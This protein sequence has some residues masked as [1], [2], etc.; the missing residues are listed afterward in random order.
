MTSTREPR[1][2]VP[3]AS[4]LRALSVCA[5]TEV[6]RVRGS[7]KKSPTLS[8]ASLEKLEDELGV[9]LH[10]DVLTLLALR[11]PIVAFF[12]GIGALNDFGD[13][14]EHAAPEGFVC[15]SVVYSDPVGE[16]VAEAHG[17]PW[18][19][20][21]VPTEPTGP[22][23][24]VFVSTDGIDA[25]PPDES[26]GVTIEAFLD[27]AI[28]AARDGEWGEHVKTASAR[29]DVLAPPP[30]LVAGRKLKL[31]RGTGERVTHAKF[32]EGTVIRRLDEGE[33]EKVVVRFAD[34]ERTLLSR[35]VKPLA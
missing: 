29:D 35:F 8:L 7:R 24:K 9:R 2:L 34:E 17:G 33:H 10:D 4:L 32:G 12:T 11:D 13:A 5:Q 16:R 26:E 21:C 3:S 18:Y 23:A 14:S 1:L 20:L 30:K 25:E 22:E 6:D 15:L 19:Y 28:H 31:D 27:D